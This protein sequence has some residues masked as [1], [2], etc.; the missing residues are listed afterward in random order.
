[1]KEFFALPKQLQLRELLRF[2]SITVGSAIFPFMAMYYVQYFGNLV[3]GILIIITQLSGFVATLYGGHL[4][5]A[6]GRKKVVIVGS[7]LATIGWAI[8]IAANVPNHITPHLT[9]VGILIIEIAH[10]FYFPAYEAMTIDLTN[11]HNRRFVYTIGYWLV[12]IAV[13]LG[14]GIAGIFYDHHFFELLIVLLIISAICCFVVYFKF[15]E[16]KPQEGTFKHDK[17]VLGTF[18]NYSQVLVDKAF[19]VYTLGAIGSSVV[20]LQVDNYF[21]VNLKQNFEVVSI[22]GHTITGAKMLSLAVFTNTLLIVLLMT[23]INKFIENWPLKRQ[24]ILGSLIC[25]FGMLFNISLNTFGAILIAMTFFTFGE[26]IYVPASQVL[27]AEM[28]VEGKI[29]SY[30]GFLAIAQP[31]ASV[32][33][34]AMVSLSYFTGKIGVQITLTI[35]MLAG[36]VL[37]LYATKMKN[38]EIGK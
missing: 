2:I 13:M 37:I 5:D 9:F 8:T 20:W 24:L 34:G 18:K 27:R 21:S 28:M 11:E 17:G 35:F 30:S 32:L 7:L 36:L 31:V 3:T 4:S 19:V 23:T 38:I 16:T 6:I 25:G 22:L 15:D 10:Q 26:M 29:G 1:M 14:S 33:A 12:N